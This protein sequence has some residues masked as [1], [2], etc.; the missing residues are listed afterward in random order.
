MATGIP[1]DQNDPNSQSAGN[2]LMQVNVPDPTGAALAGRCRGLIDESKRAKQQLEVEWKKYRRFYLANQW[3][4]NRPTYKANNVINVIHS[5]IESVL[6]IL[7]DD[8]P[9]LEAKPRIEEEYT[10]AEKITHTYKFLHRK[11]G[12]ENTIEETQLDALTYGSGFYK[13]TWDADREPRNYIDSE[14]GELAVDEMGKRRVITIG[15]VGVFRISPFL[16]Y[17]DPAA[18]CVEDCAYIIEAKPVDL[19]YIRLRYPEHVDRVKVEDI[20]LPTAHSDWSDDPVVIDHNHDRRYSGTSAGDNTEG[21]KRVMLY[22]IWV[23]ELSL[24][25]QATEQTPLAY[26]YEQFPN[27]RLITMA[28][29]VILRDI[30]FPY[31]D[32][33]YPYVKQDDYPVSDSFFGMGECPNLM[34]LQKE[35]NK[36]SSQLIENAQMIG[37]PKLLNPNQSGIDLSKWNSKPGTI[38]TYEPDFPPKFL[39]VTPLPNYIFEIL[40][41]TKRD[42]EWISGVHDVSMGRQPQGITAASAIAELQEAAQTKIR[43]KIRVRDRALEK[44]GEKMLSR[45][46]QFYD[47]PRQ[48]RVAGDEGF[49]FDEIHAPDLDGIFDIEINTGTRHPLSR[50][51]RFQEAITLSEAGKIDDESLLEVIDWPGRDKINARRREREQREM[52]MQQ[53]QMGIQQQMTIQQQQMKGDQQLEMEGM[54]Q[55][56]Q[57]QQQMPPLEG[58]PAPPQGMPPE[59]AER[60]MALMQEAMQGD[61]EMPEEIAAMIGGQPE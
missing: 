28:G 43:K 9:I 48:I 53:Q 18:T 59:E 44:V 17:P 11:L 49:T 23:K 12:M 27:G 42:V 34:P 50:A 20:P 4:K 30:P 22:E 26:D 56:G 37:N 41:S 58:M 38:I 5:T 32:G 13:V 33:E 2:A 6:P 51:G 35:L 16:I 1:I 14:T 52:E 21:R 39:E 19:D 36:R 15:E 29:D 61:G 8:L 31:D 60:L 46:R 45:I 7:T 3:P 57:M 24:L 47:E 25:R 54:R 10:K 55:E 40:E